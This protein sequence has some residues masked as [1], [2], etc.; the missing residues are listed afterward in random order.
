MQTDVSYL[1]SRLSPSFCSSAL[2]VARGEEMGARLGAKPGLAVGGG[3]SGNPDPLRTLSL[4]FVQ[5]LL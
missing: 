4:P 5:Q 3:G 1:V 2:V